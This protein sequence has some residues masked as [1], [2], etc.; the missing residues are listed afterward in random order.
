MPPDPRAETPANPRDQILLDITEALAKDPN[1]AS[2]IA[3][4]TK[5]MLPDYGNFVSR[6]MDLGTVAKTLRAPGGYPGAEAWMGDVR[7]ILTN[8]RLY[9]EADDEVM[10]RVPA[11]VELAANLVRDAE[12]AVEARA[13]DLR[14]ADARFDLGALEATLGRAPGP[15]AAEAVERAANVI[16]PGQQPTTQTATTA[17][18]DANDTNGGEVK[19]EGNDA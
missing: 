5:K 12:A 19:M 15:E 10:V 11:V 4:V 3:P 16:L 18:N 1:F 2:F 14:L 17:P 9:H 13:G 6:K 7:Q 8:A